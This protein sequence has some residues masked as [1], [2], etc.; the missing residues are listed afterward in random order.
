MQATEGELARL[1]ALA[2]ADPELRR[3]VKN[4][5]RDA[6]MREHKLELSKYLYGTTGVMLRAKDGRTCGRLVERR[7]GERER[8]AAAR[9]LHASLRASKD[10]EG[11]GRPDRRAAQI[12]KRHAPIAWDLHGNRGR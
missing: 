12:E 8:P 6:P 3:R 7:P 4:D 2:L 5:M 11:R 10:V 9:V 1:V